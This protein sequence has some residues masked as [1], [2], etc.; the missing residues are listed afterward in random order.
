MNEINLPEKR[1]SKSQNQLNIEGLLNY[2]WIEKRIY[3]IPSLVLY[4]LDWSVPLPGIEWREKE[5]ILLNEYMK[6]K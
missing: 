6:F 3:N 5:T 2:D 4:A 1:D